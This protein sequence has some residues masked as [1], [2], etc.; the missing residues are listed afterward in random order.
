[1]HSK[2]ICI[3]LTQTNIGGGLGVQDFGPR[4]L[5]LGRWVHGF[6]TKGL[7]LR[8]WGV[9][10]ENGAGKLG[11]L[12]AIFGDWIWLGSVF[13]SYVLGFHVF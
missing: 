8:V 3:I 11:V 9:G 6:E 5:G 10:L 7:P 13:R 1:M 4:A 2:S 12:R